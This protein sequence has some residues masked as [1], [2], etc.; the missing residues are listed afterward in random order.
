MAIDL[1]GANSEYLTVADESD[2]D[3]L[4]AMSVSC[5]FAAESLTKAWQSLVTKGDNSWRLTRQSTDNTI[6]FI[7]STVSSGL[8]RAIA[9][10]AINDNVLRH[11]VAVCDPTLAA[12]IRIYINGVEDGISAVFSDTLSLT[13]SPV[14]IGNNAQSTARSWDG[15]MDDVRIYDRTLSPA[16][17]ETLYT[18]RGTDAINDGLKLRADFREGSPGTV[19][20]GT[21]VKDRSSDAH[22]ITVVNSPVYAESALRSVRRAV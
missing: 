17:V 1:D 14:W 3:F 4:G 16:E 21:D 15:V 19:I 18:I 22:V 7:A 9:A 20:T 12:P 11:V 6:A 5:W 13:N 2:F 8:Q 10:T